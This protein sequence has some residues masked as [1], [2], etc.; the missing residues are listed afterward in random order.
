[1]SARS[2]H[3]GAADCQAAHLVGDKDRQPG[4]EAGAQ[5]TMR[6]PPDGAGVVSGQ[7]AAK[8]VQGSDIQP[9]NSEAGCQ[10]PQQIPMADG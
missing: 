7:A 8:Q 9:S 4:E 1:M 10:C 6:A 3:R 5:H 2:S